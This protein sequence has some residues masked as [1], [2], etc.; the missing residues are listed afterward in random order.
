MENLNESQICDAFI[1]AC[2]DINPPFYNY[3]RAR[4]AQV[5]SETSLIREAANTM[6]SAL[7]TALN[8]I[9][10]T[11]ASNNSVTLDN[12]NASDT[13]STEDGTETTIVQKAQNTIKKAL[14]PSVG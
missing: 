5:E 3:M 2:R 8:E 12:L 9:N 13:D 1:E 4:D 10:P 14:D 7:L 6:S 11:H